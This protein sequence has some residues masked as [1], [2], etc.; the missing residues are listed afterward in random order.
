MGRV[1]TTNTFRQTEVTH[2]QVLKFVASPLLGVQRRKEGRGNRWQL[3]ELMPGGQLGERDGL[4]TS[5]V[6]HR[7]Q[8][9]LRRPWRSDMWLVP[10][11]A[12]PLKPLRRVCFS[13]SATVHGEG[14]LRGIEQSCPLDLR[15]CQT[16]QDRSQAP[17]STSYLL[18]KRDT[19]EVTGTLASPRG[20]S[21][22]QQSSG[23]CD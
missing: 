12:L 1:R 16:S 3:V 10:P 20:S 15:F 17:P 18:S 13:F 9:L 2:E 5:I 6:Q 21:L 19:L 8:P 11:P 4:Q 7:V 22:C 14:H 23:C